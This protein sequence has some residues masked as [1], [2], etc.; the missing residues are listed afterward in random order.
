MEARGHCSIYVYSCNAPP[1]NAIQHAATERLPSSLLFIDVCDHCYYF[2]YCWQDFALPLP[3]LPS[4]IST[5][6]DDIG[7]LLTVNRWAKYVHNM[8]LACTMKVGCDGTVASSFFRVSTFCRK[9]WKSTGPI[10]E[11]QMSDDIMWHKNFLECLKITF[12]IESYYSKTL[13][14]IRFSFVFTSSLAQFWDNWYCHNNK[15]NIFMIEKLNAGT[16]L[17]QHKFSLVTLFL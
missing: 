1:T 2:H 17:V 4:G 15:N 13:A 10:C 12:I 8:Y 6:V 9:F 5:G 14:C 16:I 3:P 7:G 11:L